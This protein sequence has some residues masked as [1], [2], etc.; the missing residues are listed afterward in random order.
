MTNFATRWRKPA[1]SKAPPR[2]Y[3][4]NAGSPLVS[5][6]YHA[7]GQWLLTFKDGTTRVTTIRPTAEMVAIHNKHLARTA[8]KPLPEA[9]V[10]AA[11]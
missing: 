1:P 10:L 7:A 9:E 6:S 2:K 3:L 4:N 5:C 11:G 8:S